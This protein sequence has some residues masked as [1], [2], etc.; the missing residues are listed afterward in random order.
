MSEA[1]RNECTL[2]PLVRQVGA[3]AVDAMRGALRDNPCFLETDG[4]RRYFSDRDLAWAWLAAFELSDLH[5][6]ML[7][8][9]FSMP[10][11]TEQARV[12]PSP[13]SAGSPVIRGGL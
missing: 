13:G 12:L 3:R 7:E 11:V 5:A 2:D 10:N 6:A 1:K 8:A 9:K 4:T